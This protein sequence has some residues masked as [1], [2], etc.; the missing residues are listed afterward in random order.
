MAGRSSAHSPAGHALPTGSHPAPPGKCANP[1]AQVSGPLSG[2]GSHV[3]TSPETSRHP[4]GH[5]V[6][7]MGGTPSASHG[8]RGASGAAA[9]SAP[10]SAAGTGV[11]PSHE[12]ART[13][14]RA[15]TA[16]RTFPSYSVG[17][18]AAWA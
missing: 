15:T 7:A 1:S 14:T 8:I 18:R 3:T 12:D 2:Y 4:G 9:E 17:T 16:D 6:S 5:G 11:D 10:A 13:A